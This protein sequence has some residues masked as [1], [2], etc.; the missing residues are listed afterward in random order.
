MYLFFLHFYVFLLFFAVLGQLF[1]DIL[2]NFKQFKDF[3]T[4]LNPEKFDFYLQRKLRRE[5]FPLVL[6]KTHGGKI[7][8]WGMANRKTAWLFSPVATLFKRALF[9]NGERELKAP[10]DDKNSRFHFY[11]EGATY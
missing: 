1:I 11:I 6:G 4:F 10:S 7:S 2:C 8:Y 5:N 3:K 9:F